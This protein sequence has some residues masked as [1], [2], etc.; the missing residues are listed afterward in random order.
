MGT[1]LGTPGRLI[2]LRRVR[3][4][5]VEYW[6]G[7]TFQRTLEGRLKAQTKGS[8]NRAWTVS[9]AM[10]TPSD[11]ANIQAFQDGEFGRGPFVFIPAGASTSNLLD[12]DVSTCGPSAVMSTTV[13]SAGPLKLPDETWAG[14]SLSNASPA[15]TLQFG[16]ATTPVIPGGKVTA[17]AY[18]V[19]AGA[20]V[21]VQFLSASGSA[22][23]QSLST[24]AGVAGTAKRLAAT[25]TV[26]AG[27]VACK[28]YATATTL[29]ARPALTWTDSLF[30]WGIGAG[31]SK[32]MI[33]GFSSGLSKVLDKNHAASL[34]TL[35]FTVQEVG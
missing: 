16:P 20:K 21:G 14:R 30:D 25:A 31:C 2:Q 24:M 4:Q 17:S 18:V 33:H 12:P 9:M 8:R 23:T 29:A 15:S 26:P 11:L 34:S 13:S 35:S 3:T 1:Y 27:A 5:D 19:G 32:A 10:A 6:D 7:R 22:L 28:V